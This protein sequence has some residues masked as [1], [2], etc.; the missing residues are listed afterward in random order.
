MKVMK[1]IGLVLTCTRKGYMRVMK[2]IGLGL[3]CSRKRIYEGNE[4]DRVRVNMHP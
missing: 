2:R 4:R 1:G 3:T